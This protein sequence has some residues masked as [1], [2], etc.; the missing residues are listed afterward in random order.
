MRH[1]GWL[2]GLAAF[3]AAISAAGAETSGK[4]LR[5]I[6]Q[7]DLRVIDPV[8]TTALITR[9]H[10]YMVYDTLFALDERFEPQPQMV[11]SWRAEE[12]GLVH[13]FTLRPG[14]KFHD[15]QA[16]RAADAA[17]SVRRWMQTNTLGQKLAESVASIEAVDERR[18][19]IRLTRRFPLLINALG[20][21]AAPF[22]MPERIAA[23]PANKQIA[24]TIGSGPFRFVKEEWEPGH[25]AVYVRNPDYVPRT[26]K[27]SWVAG[28]KSVKV[29]RV[30]WVYIPDATTAMNALVSSEVDWWQQVPP[31]LLPAIRGKRGIVVG[32]P[33]PLGYIAVMGLNHL[34][35]PFDNEKIRQAVMLAADQRDYMQAAAG[36][37]E[38]W[39]TCFSV[40]T[41][42][43]PYAGEAG[44]E[45]LK[46]KRDL[47]KAKAL[48]REGGYKGERVVVLDG[49]DYAAAHAEA[50]V[51]ADLLRRL[52]M[53]VELQASD[54]GTVLTRRARKTSVDDG[55][56]SIFHTSFDG[57][58]AI[59]P[60]INL[61]L[62]ADGEK[63]WFGWPTDERL[64]ALKRE[65][66][67]AEDQPTRDRLAAE[68]QAQAFR[69][70][71]YIPLGQ[72]QIPT[73]WRD[74]L[75]GVIPA[76]VVLMW[77]V[78]KK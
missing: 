11:E 49:T 9:N 13:E 29:D 41:C 36:P 55:G 37:P 65:W 30:E 77:G 50:L 20:Q 14:L 18:F 47:E 53:N 1:L 58:A 15:G 8:W 52:G 7:A 19:T 6:P 66:I 31:D 74:T 10:A 48:L 42:G 59:D 60:S 44:A 45:P 76:P 51:T 39:K 61:G 35:P 33:D 71:P 43:T 62:R 34:Q 23:T 17:A 24:E 46:A 16:V 27:P 69:S 40:Y 68:I 70:V 64:E 12:G 5:F 2:A 57:P 25:K 56:W 63:A 4:T 32:A 54:W 73:A 67:Y 38:F 28:A 21:L 26:E 22:V 75:S 3:A 72:F 78:D